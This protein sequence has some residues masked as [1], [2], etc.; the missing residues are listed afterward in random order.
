[1][2]RN[3][4]LIVRPAS[5]TLRRVAVSCWHGRVE[6]LAQVDEDLDVV[7]RELHRRLCLIHPGCTHEA[8]TT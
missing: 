8:P 6:R 3:A 4:A 2:P 1:M 5:G 7:A